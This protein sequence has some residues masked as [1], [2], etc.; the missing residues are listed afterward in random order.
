MSMRVRYKG[1]FLSRKNVTWRVDILQESD[2]SFSVGDLTFDADEAL[3]ID[4]KETKKEEVICG[5]EATI[6]IISPGDRT[7]QDLYTIQ[8][9]LIAMNVYRNGNLYWSGTLDP[10]FYEE[11]YEMARGYVVSLS[12]S[13]F[14]ILDRLKYNLSGMQTLQAILNDA[15][16]R[17]GVTYTSLNTSTTSTYFADS[18]TKVSLGSLKV[19]SDNFFDEDGEASTMKEVLEGILQP[20]SLRMIQKNGG[21]Y[22]YDL[23]ALASTTPQGVVW[24]GDS[25]TMSTDR[26]ANNVKVTFSPYASKLINTEATYT[27]PVDKTKINRTSTTPVDGEYYSWYPDYNPRHGSSS[28]WDYDL[29]SFTL[30]LSSNGEGITNLHTNAR[31]F[32]IEPIYGGEESEGVCWGF[33]TGGHGS[34]ASGYPQHKGGS[35]TLKATSSNVIF[36]TI[37]VS[38]PAIVSNTSDYML[39]LSMEL[40]LDPR[41]NPWGSNDEYNEE[42]NMSA[43]KRFANFVF[44]PVC[45]ELLDGNGTVAYHYANRSIAQSSG[46]TG[47]IGLCQGTWES[48]AA[49]FDDAWL[50]Y[51]EPSDY[52]DS[53]GVTGW[54]KN[55]HTIGLAPYE[56]YDS[57][58]QMAAGQYLP[59]PP[60][61]GYL[62]VT[63]HSGVRI[64]NEDEAVWG[65]MGRAESKGL[66]GMIRFLMYKTPVVD[67]VRN[68]PGLDEISSDD[69]EYQGYLNPA[70]KE[71]MRIDTICGT[72]PEPCPIARGAYYR[73]SS[74]EQI[75]T[76]TR[77]GVTDHPEKLLIGTLYSQYA[78]RHVKLSGEAQLYSGSLCPFTEANQSG[79]VFLMEGERQNVITDC[80]DISIV[81]LSADEYDAIDEV[82]S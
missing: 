7:Y 17:S 36:K 60:T 49:S 22:I 74:G 72:L 10:E 6:R 69:I 80:S 51:Y 28:G 5:S 68:N 33:Y 25:Q 35:L 23:N 16:T 75:Q 61:G 65:E 76:M 54:K 50:E 45:I 73:V 21:I 39:R 11:P 70:A 8:P 43:F 19:R 18:N 82:N 81:E 40:L 24:D 38:I 46:R 41:Y 55:R 64:Y 53:S 66:Y 13:D 58:A 37:P 34:M 1:S 56:I 9:G 2:S 47:M 4:W 44:V 20:L 32:H 27:D 52:V 31:Y 29:I 79:K 59:Y 78:D 57:F 12:F 71:E 3:V 77:A 63:V 26:V 62:R 15:L 14:G 30:F 48:G 42:G 67:I